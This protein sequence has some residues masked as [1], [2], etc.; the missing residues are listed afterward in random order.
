MEIGFSGKLHL[1]GQRQ[2]ILT[3]HIIRLRRTIF[4]NNM[5]QPDGLF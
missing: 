2:P 5:Q 4:A 3:V 1:G